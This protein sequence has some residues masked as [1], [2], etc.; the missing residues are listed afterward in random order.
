MI[1]NKWHRIILKSKLTVTHTKQFN[2][3]SWK[4]NSELITIKLTTV[5][6][7]LQTMSIIV[8]LVLETQNVLK[9]FF[10]L[11]KTRILPH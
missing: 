1:S 9:D 10:D 8:C 7:L 2:S 6:W 4:H 11:W 5:N 3:K